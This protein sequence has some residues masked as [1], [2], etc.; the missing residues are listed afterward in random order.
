MA[1]RGDT[2]RRVE[3]LEMALAA[4]IEDWRLIPYLQRHEFEALVLAELDM[5]KEVLDAGEQAGVAAL[6]ALVASVPPEDVNDS[7]ETAPSKRLDDAVP[8]YRKT[9]HGLLA[10]EATGLA[11]LRTACPRFDA[12]LRRLEALSAAG[13]VGASGSQP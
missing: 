5:L 2:N 7:P 6:E 8:S 11:K 3:L 1:E 10:V 12:W 9:V 13:G 4:D